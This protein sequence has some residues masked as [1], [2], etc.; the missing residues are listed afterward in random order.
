M[1]LLLRV[2]F[3]FFFDIILYVGAMTKKMSACGHVFFFLVIVAWGLSG[4]A[5]VTKFR[6]NKRNI[7]INRGVK[8]GKKKEKTNKCVLAI[9][10]FLGVGGSTTPS[11][12]GGGGG[13]KQGVYAHA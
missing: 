7:E 8:K 4:R 10:S 11:L 3:F 1:G 2:V 13:Y 9:G 12:D 5:P 6:D